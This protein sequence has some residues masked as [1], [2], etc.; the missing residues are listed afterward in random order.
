MDIYQTKIFRLFRDIL[1]S[2]KKVDDIDNNDMAT[3]FEYYSAIRLSEEFNQK[4]YMYS[5]INPEFK[6][7]N[8]LTQ[9][10]SGIDLCNLIDYIV[11]CKLRKN[12]L[13]WQDVGINFKVNYIK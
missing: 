1:K 8:K 5:D 9:Q 2:G 6:E 3:I 11:Q 10:Y 4:F 12:N 13:C 7:Q